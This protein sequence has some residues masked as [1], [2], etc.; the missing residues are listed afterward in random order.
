MRAVKSDGSP[1]SASRDRKERILTAAA[2]LVSKSGYH[3]VSMG[4]IGAAAGV[5]GPAIY[6]HFGSKSALLVALFD[7]AID[8]LVQEAHDIERGGADPETALLALV[9]SQVRFVVVDRSVAQVYYSEI[10]SLPESDR[11]RL[12]RKQ[13]LYLEEWVH[14]L[15]ELRPDLDDGQ[16]R[17]VVHAAIGAIQST[18]FHAQGPSG[19]RLDALLVKAAEAVLAS[20]TSGETGTIE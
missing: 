19:G 9:V 17:A 14:I 6:R 12:R 5:T 4:D 2:E 1:T 10:Q 20:P 3:A 18:L 7:R 16:A 8:R 11:R 15:A 13:R